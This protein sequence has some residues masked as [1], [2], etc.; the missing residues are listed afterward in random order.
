[1]LASQSPFLKDLFLSTPI[2]EEETVLIVPGAKAEDLDQLVSFL[3]GRTPEVKLPAEIFR[4]LELVGGKKAEPPPPVLFNDYNSNMMDN[5]DMDIDLDTAE[6][7]ID[8]QELLNSSDS[9]APLFCIFCNN[10][11]SSKAGLRDHLRHHPICVLCNNQF[12]RNSDL[13]EHWQTHPQ[14]GLC[15]ER[16][17]DQAALADHELGHVNIE[18]S[19]NNIPVINLSGKLL[20][21]VFTQLTGTF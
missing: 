5:P 2:Y 14:C 1:M 16:V 11:F 6:V 18:D 21:V 8:N 7:L 10:G 20:F 17:V 12:V 13:L 9:L 4:R 15:G 19:L 3:Y